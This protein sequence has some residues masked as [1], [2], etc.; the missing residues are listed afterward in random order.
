MLLLISHLNTTK[1]KNDF[2]M[3]ENSGLYIII[4]CADS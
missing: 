2:N 1:L 3:R 4:V